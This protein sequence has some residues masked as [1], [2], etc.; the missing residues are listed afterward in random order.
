[1]QALQAAH[2]FTS[3]GDRLTLAATSG[4]DTSTH[5]SH[6]SHADAGQWHSHCSAHCRYANRCANSNQLDNDRDWT[7]IDDRSD[8]TALLASYIDAIDRKAY[9][10]YYGD[11]ETPPN[12]QSLEQFT[13]GFTDTA[14]V[15]LIINP[16]T[17]QEGA[18]GSVYASVPTVLVATHTDHIPYIFSGCYVARRSN[19]S[20]GNAPETDPWQLY[21]GDL[22]AA[23]ADANLITLLQKACPAAPPLQGAYNN[24]STPVD[25]LAS[26]VDAL[27]RK[28]TAAPMI[29]GKR[30]PIS[31][32]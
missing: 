26:F 18:V 24:L 11:R 23:S 1:M 14:S 13:Q 28:E 20:N 7:D 4:G 29:I 15:D 22:A 30:H 3:T 31:R 2:R 21:R 27:N 19:Q 8:P 10:R 17:H 32:R 16:P 9:P 25:L 6:R 12:N 5:K